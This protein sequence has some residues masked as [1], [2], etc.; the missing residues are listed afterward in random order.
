MVA[1]RATEPYRL[2]RARRGRGN[3]TQHPKPLF[4]ARR[5][6][7]LLGAM[8]IAAVYFIVV[9]WLCAIEYRCFFYG[10]DLAW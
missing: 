10:F 3:L 2:Q 7:A 1:A 8:G 9:T 5:R 4:G 6:P